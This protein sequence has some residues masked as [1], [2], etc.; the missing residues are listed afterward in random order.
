V[1]F[2]LMWGIHADER[3]VPVR[4]A[5]MV[6]RHL[7]QYGVQVATNRSVNGVLHNLAQRRVV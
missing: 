1:P 2:P 4:F 5:R 6:G 7:L 3:Q